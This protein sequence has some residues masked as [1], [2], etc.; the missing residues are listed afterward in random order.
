ML[1]GKKNKV[2][3][4]DATEDQLQLAS[5]KEPS[6]CVNPLPLQRRVFIDKTE[7]RDGF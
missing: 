2:V 6:T 1:T 3:K 7:F 4:Q 5:K